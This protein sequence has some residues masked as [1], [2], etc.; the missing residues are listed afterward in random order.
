M[1][2]DSPKTH[3][4]LIN[5]KLLRASAFCIVP[6]HEISGLDFCFGE[7]G[8]FVVDTLG[9]GEAEACLWIEIEIE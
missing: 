4:R 1:N 7:F 2:G 8:E 9:D 6:I 3:I 5:S